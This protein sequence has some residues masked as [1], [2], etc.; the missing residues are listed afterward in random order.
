M[1]K[2]TGLGGVFIK[3]KD[4]KKLSQWYV[5]TLGVPTNE[6]G[7]CEFKEEGKG[8]FSIFHI[9]SN[10]DE[11]FKPS[12]SSAM[13]NFR[14]DNLDSVLNRFKKDGVKVYPDIEEETYGRFGWIEDSDGN[15]V[16][17]WDPN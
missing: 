16:E 14:V 1:G 17:L 11:Y 2:I 5:D 7:V 6:N 9:F 3:S 4:N 12:N 10:D 8:R 13:I 15:K